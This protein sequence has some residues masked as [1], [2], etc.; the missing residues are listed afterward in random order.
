MGLALGYILH[1]MHYRCKHLNRVRAAFEMRLLYDKKRCYLGNTADN[2][3]KWISHILLSLAVNCQQQARTKS[4]LCIPMHC[5][6]QL[7]QVS[8]LH[9]GVLFKS[10]FLF[11][12]SFFLFPDTVFLFFLC[13]IL[14]FLSLLHVFVCSTFYLWLFAC[15]ASF[16]C[17]LF[18]DFTSVMSIFV[19]DMCAIENKLLLLYYHFDGNEMA[20]HFVPSVLFTDHRLSWV[21]AVL[22]HV[23]NALPH[24]VRR[25]PSFAG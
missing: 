25:E 20:F 8:F 2:Q 22:R 12:L 1:K 9:L 21:G 11:C 4:Q 14:L 3:P 5:S 18:N 10:C 15:V 24:H 6:E 13:P 17:M 19:M 16:Y 7:I 23:V